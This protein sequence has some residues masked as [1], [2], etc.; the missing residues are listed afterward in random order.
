MTSSIVTEDGLVTLPQHVLDQLG[1]GPGDE[2]EFRRAA[3]G[4]IVI[5]KV[6][7]V[8]APTVV[9]DRFDRVRGITGPSPSTDEIMAELRGD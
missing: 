8:V 3:D 1:V 7:G 9:P 6:N 5:E 4:K 2:V